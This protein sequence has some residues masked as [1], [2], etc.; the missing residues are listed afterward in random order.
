MKSSG[1]ACEPRPLAYR[2]SG[3]ELEYLRAVRA[4]FMHAATL[5]TQGVPSRDVG[6]V[7]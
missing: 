6:L 5:A 2:A 3:A 1:P 4:A 7:S